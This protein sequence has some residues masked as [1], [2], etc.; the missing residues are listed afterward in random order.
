[1]NL[2]N[3]IDNE[4]KEMFPVMRL[5]GDIPRKLECPQ[6]G[7]YWKRRLIQMC[8]QGHSIC[9]GWQAHFPPNTICRAQPSNTR[10]VALEN[11]VAS[12]VYPCPFAT[13]AL[14]DFC[15]WSGNP[16]EIWSHVRES[17]DIVQ[18]I[19]TGES[20]WIRL[21][22][23]LVQPF[24]K[25][26][27]TL[28]TLLFLVF[29]IEEN[30][31]CFLLFHVGHNDDSSG[32]TYD[33]KIQRSD[34][35]NQCF[36]KSGVIRH[37]Y[38]KNLD[39]LYVSREYATLHFVSIPRYLTDISAVTCDINIKTKRTTDDDYMIEKVECTISPAD[40]DLTNNITYVICPRSI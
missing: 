27:F 16:F 30:T 10:N 3:D 25:P 23:P 19:G 4:T 12:E 28:D 38:P 39:E 32:C 29:F 35:Q 18:V 17:H 1:V 36:Y 33:F 26:I 24:L 22:L 8:E 5:H 7:D 31:L 6:F 40:L 15:A 34:N 37:N 21:S 20:G 14:G 2:G 13:E 9:H 11:M